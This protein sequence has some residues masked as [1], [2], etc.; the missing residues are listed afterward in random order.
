MTD[1]PLPPMLPS[2]DPVQLPAGFH[3]KPRHVFVGELAERTDTL[4][5]FVALSLI[6]GLG[7]KEFLMFPDRR[8][9]TRYGQPETD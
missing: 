3:D 8:L 7:P 6:S 1:M 9:T 2:P 4:N 5:R